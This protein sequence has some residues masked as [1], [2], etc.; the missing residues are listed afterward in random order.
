MNERRLRK[1]TVALLVLGTVILAPTQLADY[2]VSRDQWVP[3]W[4]FFVY[5]VGIVL[6]FI[7]L[8]MGLFIAISSRI[9]KA[10]GGCGR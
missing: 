6:V 2:N 5:Q 10:K 4:S 3:P 8:G 7:G 1:I 9:G